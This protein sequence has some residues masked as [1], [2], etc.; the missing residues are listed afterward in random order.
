MNQ[1]WC[2]ACCS[3]LCT[4]GRVSVVTAGLQGL[5]Q[6]SYVW[7]GDIIYIHLTYQKCFWSMRYESRD[8]G[9]FHCH[10]WLNL[11]CKSICPCL[12]NCSCTMLSRGCKNVIRVST[13]VAYGHTSSLE[14]IYTFSKLTLLTIFAPVW[15]AWTSPLIL[16]ISYS[17]P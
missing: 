13:F 16:N 9:Y 14:G 15:L 5:P 6:S 17:Q 11:V 7:S 2:L 12:G 4:L 10:N 3:T 8:A 1:A